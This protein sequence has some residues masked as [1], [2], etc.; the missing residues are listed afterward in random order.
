MEDPTAKGL[1]AEEKVTDEDEILMNQP[2]TWLR[3]QSLH[4]CGV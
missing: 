4:Y 1:I 3:T 2:M